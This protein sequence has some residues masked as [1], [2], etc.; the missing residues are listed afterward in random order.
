VIKP[1]A[2]WDEDAGTEILLIASDSDIAEM[3]RMKLE[4]D[5][6]LVTRADG[7]RDRK[8][9]RA[10]WKPD[11]VMID[12]GD[13]GA[14]RLVELE[15]LRSD[16]VLGTIPVLLLSTD[17][18]V[19]LRRRGLTLRPTDYVLKVAQ[20]SGLGGSLEHWSAVSFSSSAGRTYSL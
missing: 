12:L 18:E 16:P 7:V 3:Y 9:S 17:S 15:R 2:E 19:E 8:P 10:G 4:L 11:L 20:A 1:V 14:A 6:Y 13:A 5:G